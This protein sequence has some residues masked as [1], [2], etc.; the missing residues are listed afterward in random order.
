ML[1][2]S[3][4]MSADDVAHA[5]KP[6]PK[7]A[8]DTHF[9]IFEPDK[10]PL[11]AG[12]HFTPSPASLEQLIAFEESIGVEL[13]VIA[14]GLS[15]GADCSSLLHYLDCFQGRARGICVLD[16]D[17]VSDAILDQYDAAGVRSV[18][19][20]FFR[21][22]A[23]HDVHKQIELIQATGVR[24]QRWRKGNNWSVQVQQPH[25]DYWSQLAP[26]IANSPNSVVVDHLALIQAPSMAGGEEVHIFRREGWRQLLNALRQGNLWIKISAPYRCSDLFPSFDDLEEV[27]KSIVATNS[28][29]ILWGSDW[30][31]TQRHKDRI[32]QACDAQEQYLQVDDAAW[33]RSLSRWLSDE[34]WHRMWVDNPRRLYRS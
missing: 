30:P 4:R 25:L 27:V 21:H 8:W 22:S 29:R 2:D 1:G 13:L 31:H 33:I 15:F 3:D 7:G 18:R 19:I 17:N 20:D 11:A 16:L 14:H 6:V 12:R 34:Q 9:H 24:L 28:D 26:V 23:M 32:N 5:V 10:F